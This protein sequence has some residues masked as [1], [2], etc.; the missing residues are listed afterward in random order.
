M[1]LPKSIRASVATGTICKAS[2]FFDRRVRTILDEL[3]QNARRAGATIIE[4]DVDETDVAATDN[5]S[6]IENPEVVLRLGE[7]GWSAETAAREHAAG[8]GLFSLAGCGCTIESEAAGRRW[9]AVLRPQHFE[10]QESAAIEQIEATGKSGTQ[11]RFRH[12][13]ESSRRPEA[14]PAEAAPGKESD[15]QSWRAKR[16]RDEAERAARRAGL[17]APLRMTLN[18]EA[19]ERKD[20]LHGCEY[21]ER[22]RGLRIGVGPAPWVRGNTINFGGRLI[23]EQLEATSLKDRRLWSRRLPHRDMSEVYIDV[24]GESGLELTLPQREA[25]VRNEFWHELEAEARRTVL[26]SYQ[27]AGITDASAAV[28]AEARAAGIELAPA[29]AALRK[30]QPARSDE[31]LMRRTE[32]EV[33]RVAEDAYVIAPLGHSAEEQNLTRALAARPEIRA[34]HAEIGYEGYAWYD[35]L[36]KITRTELTGAEEETGAGCGELA[37]V[38]HW[39]SGDTSGTL[40]LPTDLALSGKDG[41]PNEVAEANE[42]T[43]AWTGEPPNE[44]TVTELIT[45][46]YFCPNDSADCDSPETQKAEWD[47]VAAAR[48]AELLGGSEAGVQRTVREMARRELWRIRDKH[49]TRRVIIDIP[50]W[51]SG[52]SMDIRIETI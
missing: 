21:Q 31:W 48:A 33:E 23:A 11:V 43:I 20:F 6:G 42:A 32:S 17:Y 27:A 13:E 29:A 39:R 18:G 52:R 34:Y 50:S 4:I 51:T 41:Q 2:A 15:T 9:K 30:W 10:G 40:R 19:V 3:V 49:Q 12:G 44:A 8:M 22:W 16:S 45:A 24:V 25:V 7:S 28:Y 35:A 14:M 1:K 38:A 46:A 26:R 37:V 5:G 47:G 36:R